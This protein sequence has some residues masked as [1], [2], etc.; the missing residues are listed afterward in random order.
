MS[1][2][3]KYSIRSV[4]ARRLTMI[5]TVLGISLVA[6]VFAAVLMLAEGL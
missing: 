3:I 4:F 1:I 5:L 6:F 2:P